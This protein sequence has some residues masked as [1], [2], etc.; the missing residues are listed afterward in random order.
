MR[1]A[2]PERC[3]KKKNLIGMPLF[4][5]RTKHGI[6][7]GLDFGMFRLVR[8]QSKTAPQSRL[9]HTKTSFAVMKCV[10]DETES[11]PRFQAV[12]IRNVYSRR[13]RWRSKYAT[14]WN[15]RTSTGVSCIVYPSRHTT[16]C[17]IPYLLEQNPPSNRAHLNLNR[18]FLVLV[19]L[20]NRGFTKRLAAETQ[21][22]YLPL[23]SVGLR[24]IK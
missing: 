22:S 14:H 1:E 16:D 20:Y 13:K 11:S 5:Q 12:L 21:K 4:H 23:F 19:A 3:S 8:M 6:S 2:I 7:I 17:H 9:P 15:P 10:G 18:L 24:E